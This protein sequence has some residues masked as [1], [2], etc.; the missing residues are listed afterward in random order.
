MT[1]DRYLI[2]R[3]RGLVGEATLVDQ[4]RYLTSLKLGLDPFN[5]RQTLRGPGF[6]LVARGD[7]EKLERIGNAL[8]ALGYAWGIVEDMER[9]V[10][11]F[12]V[13]RFH[14][15]GGR[16][17]FEGRAG[18]R[19][20]S[21]DAPVLAVLSSL[22]DELLGKLA[23]K[24]AVRR[25]AT[26]ALTEDEKLQTI[27]SGDAVLDLYVLAS[28]GSDMPKPLEALRLVAGKYDPA[29]LGDRATTSRRTNTAHLVELLR[30]NFASFVLNMDFVFSRLPNSQ[31]RSGPGESVQQENLDALAVFGGY[32]WQLARQNVLTAE[33]EPLTAGLDGAARALAGLTGV[34]DAIAESAADQPDAAAEASAGSVLPPPPPAPPKGGWPA[35]V[36]TPHA[37]FM[38]IFYA[39][40]IFMGWIV[41]AVQ[42]DAAH[43][44]MRYAFGRGYLLLLSAPVLFYE[45]FYYLRL[46]RYI[47]NTPRSKARSAAV[48]MVEMEGRAERAYNVLAPLTG[49]P[50][51][52]FRLQKYVKEKGYQDQDY[53]RRISDIDSGHV[54][55]YLRDDT[56]R[57][58][59]DPNGAK[60]AP[61]DS[62]TYTG[63]LGSPWGLSLT[64]SDDE[65]FVEDTIPEGQQVFVV[66]FASPLRVERPSL[67]S[68]IADK[69]RALKGSPAKMRK[70]DT[71]KDGRIDEQEW[72]RARA[73]MERRA[74]R[75]ILAEEGA[76]EAA[77]AAL[78]VQRPRHR[79]LPF[80]I[81][82]G[83]EKRAARRYTWYSGL[84]LL[85]AIALLAGG[86]AALLT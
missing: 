38:T 61:T 27:I 4:V 67:R 9:R 84:F 34:A 82:G 65:K 45:A 49:M 70:Y 37:V 71:N 18:E 77:T 20:V 66:G 1:G 5:L 39:L 80:M 63:V 8:G 2:V 19:A 21:C 74:L 52:Y 22:H 25:G 3:R 56:G 26:V 46:K 36:L 11:A 83:T 62:E 59:I 29:S 73:D 55:F 78:V 60:I 35:R 12:E 14:V 23:R 69:L 81:A 16:V 50:C 72:E 47:E 58:L 64:I 54:P 86:V 53:W 57:V 33:G 6:S 13:R 43:T 79:G 85:T 41:Q 17:V 51:I 76:D 10:R 40:W 15:G 30:E 32:L 7:V 28:P 44:V 31:Y 75:E 42:S 24:A 48:G 68:R